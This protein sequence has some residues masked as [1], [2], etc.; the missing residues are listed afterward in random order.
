MLQQWRQLHWFYWQW[1]S[2]YASH[3]ATRVRYKHRLTV[4][5]RFVRS[6]IAFTAW[7]HIDIKT[8][9][10]SAIR[11]ISYGTNRHPRTCP[12]PVITPTCL[13]IS[14][15]TVIIITALHFPAR[16]THSTPHCV[17]VVHFMTQ[18]LFSIWYCIPPTF[19]MYFF[20][21]SSRCDFHRSHRR[22]PQHL[23]FWERAET[24]PKSELPL[25]W[26]YDDFYSGPQRWE[27]LICSRAKYLTY[28]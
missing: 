9:Q 26:G 13:L 5:V 17:C 6:H 27:Q 18:L 28:K 8:L 25:T 11:P 19:P 22:P 4:R 20:L 2:V 3:S 16:Q 10:F 23:L 14:L 7:H 21:M 12:C 1:L 15:Y 24:D